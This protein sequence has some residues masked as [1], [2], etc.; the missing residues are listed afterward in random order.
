MYSTVYHLYHNT[1]DIRWVYHMWRAF[2]FAVQGEQ[3]WLARI[4]LVL[5]TKCSQK[6]NHVVYIVTCITH[7][8]T[9]AM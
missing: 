2:Q 4:T 9:H 6:L 8:L 7:L 1:Q 3:L 5:T